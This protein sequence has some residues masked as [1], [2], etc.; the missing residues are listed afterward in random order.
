MPLDFVNLKLTAGILLVL[1]G[2][3]I[4]FMAAMNANQHFLNAGIGVAVIGVILMAFSE[5]KRFEHLI[6]PY[7]ESLKR[8]AE[9]TEVKKAVYI[10]PF[11]NFTSV[12]VFLAASNE[13]EIDI[14]R[15]DLNSPFVSGREKEMGILLEAPGKEILKKFEE[16]AEIDLSNYG[17]GISEICSSVLKALELADKVE[18]EENG[19]LK[20]TISGAKVDFCSD[21]CKLIQCPICSSVLSATAKAIGELIAVDDFRVG[22]KIEIRV[23]KLGGIE[24]WM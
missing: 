19:D 12:A 15:L 22:D 24:R 8:I 20:I 13:F 14:S 9:F 2:I 10:P 18:I 16:Y 21:D 4:G 11:G 17:I 7:H 1:A 5:K 3:A 6:L 23:K